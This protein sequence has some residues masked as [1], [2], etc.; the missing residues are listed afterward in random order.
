M[1]YLFSQNSCRLNLQWSHDEIFWLFQC[2]I[3][4]LHYSEEILVYF[5]LLSI[6][7][8]SLIFC[9]ALLFYICLLFFWKSLLWRNVIRARNK[10]RQHRVHCATLIAG[11]LCLCCALL[12]CKSLIILIVVLLF[13]HSIHSNGAGEKSNRWWPVSSVCCLCG[14]VRACR[15]SSSYQINTNF[16]VWCEVDAW[17]LSYTI[18]CAL[19]CSA[20]MLFTGCRMFP[21]GTFGHSSAACS[22]M[23]SRQV[24]NIVLWYLLSHP[25]W[26]RYCW[27]MILWHNDVQ[28]CDGNG[29][30]QVSKRLRTG[31]RFG[32]WALGA[33][34]VCSRR[35]SAGEASKSFSKVMEWWKLIMQ[36]SSS[37]S[38]IVM[39]LALLYVVVCLFRVRLFDFVCVIMLTWSC[40]EACVIYFL[41]PRTMIY[42]LRDR[43]SGVVGCALW[44][45]RSFCPANSVDGLVIIL[46]C[47]PWW[48]QLLSFGHCVALDR[49]YFNCARVVMSDELNVNVCMM[50][51][52]GCCPFY[53]GSLCG[54]RESEWWTM[55]VIAEH[56]HYFK[57]CCA[58][59]D[60]VKY[61]ATKHDAWINERDMIF[62][63]ALRQF[64]CS[65]GARRCP[66][67]TLK[68]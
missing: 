33:F 39:L 29:D 14:C 28:K 18:W 26:W 42:L 67:P 68:W 1:S 38:I 58:Q 64:V 45:Y 65:L 12:C 13:C 19:L 43:Y 52:V 11:P 46:L 20:V 53:D 27:N 32:T 4:S 31:W 47:I 3:F 51:C 59:K 40:D 9:C 55:T 22:R 2:I 5:V 61:L 44:G 16:S 15:T 54:E 66:S 37:S 7:D 30:T 49:V 41:W 24:R 62:W 34:K 57:T 35:G 10:A 60:E 48:L 8:F 25:E 36:R 6:S 17:H 21:F 50:H 56:C 63:T 23:C